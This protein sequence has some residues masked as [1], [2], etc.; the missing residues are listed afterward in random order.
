MHVLPSS[1]YNFEDRSP[2]K[3]RYAE[4]SGEFGVANGVPVATAVSEDPSL[5]AKYPHS[6]AR[7]LLTCNLYR[8][9]QAKALTTRWTDTATQLWHLQLALSISS[10]DSLLETIIMIPNRLTLCLDYYYT[11]L[12]IN[13]IIHGNLTSGRNQHNSKSSYESSLSLYST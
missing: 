6:L 11:A 2:C 9:H 13:G 4:D 5:L 10:M 3:K 7:F 12:Y 8:R 1:A